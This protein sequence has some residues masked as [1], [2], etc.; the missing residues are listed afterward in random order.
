MKLQALVRG[1]NARKQAK[2]TLKCM[3]ALVRVQDR[4]SHQRARLSL[5]GRRKS[6]VAEIASLWDSSYLKD[7]HKRV[8][9]VRNFLFT[10]STY[11]VIDSSVKLLI[12][13]NHV[14]ICSQERRVVLWMIGRIARKQT[15]RLK[16]SCR[17]KRKQL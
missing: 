3:Q 2:L 13:Y 5:E 11:L 4:V 15:R 10:I 8:S 16:Q 17:V 7:I 6:M 14:F 12:D 1:Q 9:L